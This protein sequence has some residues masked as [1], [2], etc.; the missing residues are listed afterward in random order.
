MTSPQV[1]PAFGPLNVFR[2]KELAGVAVLG[3]RGSIPEP[4]RRVGQ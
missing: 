4:R 2:V 1:K 3:V